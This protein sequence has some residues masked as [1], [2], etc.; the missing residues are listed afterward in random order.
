[1]TD[2]FINDIKSQGGS[3]CAGTK[4]Y[5]RSAFLSALNA[6]SNFGTGG[7][8]DVTKREVAAFFAHVTHET[9]RMS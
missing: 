3:G 8:S 5:T 1:M 6:Y 9:G 2:A 7:S 4:F